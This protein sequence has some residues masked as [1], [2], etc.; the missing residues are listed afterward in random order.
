[1]KK[2][3]KYLMW[4]MY[5]DKSSNVKQA[6]GFPY[7]NTAIKQRESKFVSMYESTGALARQKPSLE[8]QLLKIS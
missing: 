6:N 8:K 5:I 3:A 4:D 1:M 2:T 7:K